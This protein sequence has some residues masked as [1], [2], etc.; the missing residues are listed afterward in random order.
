MTDRPRNPIWD[1]L[2]VHFGEPRTK[3]EQRRRGKAVKELKDAEATPEEIAITIDYCKRHFT[4]FTEFAIC[5]WLT[6]ALQE[7]ATWEKEGNVF[8]LAKKRMENGGF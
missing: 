6:R 7:K 3:A 2:S 1:A 4:T 8:D 5:G